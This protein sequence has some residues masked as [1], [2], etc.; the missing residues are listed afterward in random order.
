MVRVAAPL[1]FRVF[2]L[3]EQTACGITRQSRLYCWGLNEHG[4]AGGAGGAMVTRPRAV[5][6]ALRFA[7]VSV[8][9]YNTCALTEAGEL[10]CWGQDYPTPGDDSP[11]RTPQRIPAEVRFAEIEGQAALTVDGAAWEWDLVYHGRL[12]DGVVGSCPSGR[13][14]CM[15][16]PRPRAE[17]IRFRQLVPGYPL[18]C[19]ITVEGR[20][21]CVRGGDR[22]AVAAPAEGLIAVA[23]GGNNACGMTD[24]HEV[25]C[26]GSWRTDRFGNRATLPPTVVPRATWPAELGDPSAAT[27]APGDTA[28]ASPKR[29]RVPAT[30]PPT[31]VRP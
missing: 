19:G 28:G 15:G 20:F 16:P 24:R 29:G 22:V 7:R 27:P 26:W 3:S 1:T 14:S 10:W 21:H 13:A 11:R 25:V 9:D 5:L 4:Q 2:G 6:P 12:V 23:F 31:S 30:G 18:G 17:G 8:M